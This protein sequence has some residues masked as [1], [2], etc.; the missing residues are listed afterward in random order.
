MVVMNKLLIILFFSINVF[1]QNNETGSL[2]GKWNV[3]DVS[4]GTPIQGKQDEIQMAKMFLN[5]TWLPSEA[6][7]FSDKA[8]LEKLVFWACEHEKVINAIKISVICFI[9]VNDFEQS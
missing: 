4:I 6:N 1:S 3:I 5:A 8:S 2:V 9:V 7:N